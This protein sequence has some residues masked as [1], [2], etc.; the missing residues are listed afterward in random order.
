[1]AWGWM[2]LKLNLSHLCLGQQERMDHE[3]REPNEEAKKKGRDLFLTN[4]ISFRLAY[5]GHC[6]L[7]SNNV[8]PLPLT[9][10]A[11]PQPS[12]PAANP[13][14]KTVLPLHR[15]DDEPLELSL[16]VL[17]LLVLVLAYLRFTIDDC[18]VVVV[19][20]RRQSGRTTLFPEWVARPRVIVSSCWGG[21]MRDGSALRIELVNMQAIFWGVFCTSC[22]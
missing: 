6:F 4:S 3:K 17:L 22:S 20:N 14:P 1:M 19:D 7:L 18:A 12:K 2:V 9:I 16:L 8:I 5:R 15:D 21:G 10:V 11:K 13:T